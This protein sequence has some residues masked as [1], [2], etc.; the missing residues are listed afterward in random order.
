MQLSEL[1]HNRIFV[2]AFAGLA[3]TGFFGAA[4]YFENENIEE[5]RGQIELRKGE[6]DT[7]QALVA[8]TPD[9]VKEVVVE[10]ETDAVVA[11]LLPNEEAINNF[12]RTL[13]GFEEAAGVRITAVKKKNVNSK[14]KRD[15]DRV[16]YQLTFEGD[17][18]GLIAFIDQV[19]SDS[20]FMSVPSFKLSPGSRDSVDAG[21]RTVHKVTLDVETYVY[22]P[23]KASEPRRIDGYDRKV[24]QLAAE[25]DEARAML[26]VDSYEYLGARDRRDPFVDP[27]TP[28]DSLLGP[29]MTLD[30]Q[31][32]A[33]DGLLE[34][35]EDLQAFW[36]DYQAMEDFEMRVQATVTFEEELFKLEEDVRLLQVEGTIRDLSQGR[37]FRE[38]LLPIVDELRVAM[39]ASQY[40]QGPG[41]ELLAEA[42]DVMA[43]HLSVG[44][45]EEALAAMAPLETGLDRAA[46][47]ADRLPLVN[48]IRDLAFRA[49]TAMDFDAL[50]LDVGGVIVG[51]YSV[52]LVDGISV[53]EGEMVGPELF[54]KSI[55]EDRVEFLFRGV[56]LA[57]LI[58]Q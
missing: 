13:R 5:V 55:E 29:M 22:E 45:F 50:D 14:E 53:E 32:A 1:I 21:G 12:V 54:V 49:R 46:E 17:T 4:I 23:Q 56:A 51:E 24:Q 52:A 26:Q 40:G 35:A 34:R 39:G 18:F 27:R 57:R 37:R 11:E 28:A 19:E 3:L 48:E 20:R 6:I 38:D 8:G 33:V 9:L 16:V 30:E 44:R 47:D 43:G 7:A 36:A 42:R 10:R 58:T 31:I 25:I 15:F 41:F 2:S